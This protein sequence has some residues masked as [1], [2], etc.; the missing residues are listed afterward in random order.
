MSGLLIVNADDW[1][2]D[3]ATTD[4][5]AACFA[6]GRVT[7]ATAMVFMADS[8][9]AAALAQRIALP[10]G[11]H[12][13]L[14]EPFTGAEVPASVRVRQ[15]ALA[16]RFGER[17]RRWRRWI[18]DPR[19][20]AAVERCVRDQL[21]G[22]RDLYGREPTHVDGHK[23]VHVS[24]T[25]ARTPAL[26]GLMLRRAVSDPAGDRSPMARAR[27]FRHRLV[28]AGTPGTEH[29]LSIW[30][31]REP[32]LRGEQPAALAL[33]EHDAVEV[34]A[35]PGL[36]DEHALLMT[37]AWARAVRDLRRGSYEDLG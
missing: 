36:A 33:A 27:R 9:R 14:S 1:G 6:D 8:E 10:V 5:I 24:P 18:P 23:H 4:A 35:H 32:L 3:V 26:R 7:S 25:V 15:A 11:L 34:M 21:E 37:D 20:G 28:L 13:N 19:I 2:L 16:A 30:S 12:L 31:M 29:F 22:F 17:G